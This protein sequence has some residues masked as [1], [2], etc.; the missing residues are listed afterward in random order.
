MHLLDDLLTLS[1]PPDNRKLA[2]VELCC[3]AG[4]MIQKACETS[5]MRYSG[6]VKDVE[7][8]SVVWKV[9]RFLEEQKLLGNWTHMQISTPCTSGSPFR[10]C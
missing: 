8:K 5:D 4:S 9:K 10:T 3:K 1:M 6:V 7:I 2:V